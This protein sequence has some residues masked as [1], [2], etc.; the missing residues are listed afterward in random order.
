MKP[1][2]KLG[3]I[4]IQ[5]L[6]ARSLNRLL[7]FFLNLFSFYRIGQC[8]GA[9]NH[10]YFFQFISFAVLGTGLYLLAATNTFYYN[11]WRVCVCLCLYSTR[12]HN[13]HSETYR[14]NPTNPFAISILRTS[15]GSTFYASKTVT[16][17]GS[18]VWCFLHISFV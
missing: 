2:R 9:K 10:R 13:F 7:G 8:V 4:N 6:M 1:C 5:W 17:P 3:Q 16:W 12:V 14:L 11:F 18:V 15:L